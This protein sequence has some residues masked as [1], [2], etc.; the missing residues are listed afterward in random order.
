MSV[1]EYKLT[2]G[3][4]KGETLEEVYLTDREWLEWAH[5]NIEKDGLQ[6]KIEDLFDEMK[7]VKIY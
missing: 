5:E 3:K 7:A 6:E 2:F 1:R 4:H